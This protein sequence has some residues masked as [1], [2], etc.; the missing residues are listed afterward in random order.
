MAFKDYSAKINF[1]FFRLYRLLKQSDCRT[2]YNLWQIFVLPLLRMP[3]SM[4][5]VADS[6]R[7]REQVESIKK[8]LR[9]ALKKFM[10][11]P[12]SSPSC[13]IGPMTNYDEAAIFGM[14]EPWEEQ[15]EGRTK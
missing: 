3:V 15:S 2:R 9:C 5:G 8:E 4:I 12:R 10:L 6:H 11:L 7:F 13:I 14:V 1:I